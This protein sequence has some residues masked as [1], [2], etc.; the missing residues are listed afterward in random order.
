[1]G[2]EESTLGENV[3]VYKAKNIFLNF[4][5]ILCVCGGEF[6]L[7]VCL[8]TTCTHAKCPHWL[9]EDAVSRRTEVIGCC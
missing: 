6:F 7:H 4:I 3:L 2:F 5:F 8:C 1:M 9:E